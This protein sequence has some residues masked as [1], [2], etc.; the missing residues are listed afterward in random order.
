M[1]SST[2]SGGRPASR[3]E[4]VG[5]LYATRTSCAEQLEQHRKA[6]GGVAVVV[7][8]QHAACAC[9]VPVRRRAG[10][11]RPRRGRRKR[12]PHDELA[13]VARPSLC[14]VDRAAVQL[15]QASHQRQPD[16]EAALRTLPCG[17]PG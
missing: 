3:L 4:R 1:S 17:S 11:P 13:A 12:Q 7:D 6:V 10:S 8:H 5:P 9:G 14:A 15:D 16:A 2:T